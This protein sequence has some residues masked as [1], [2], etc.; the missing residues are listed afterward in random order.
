MGFRAAIA[1]MGHLGVELDP[2]ALAESDRVELAR[3]ISFYKDWR[4]LLHQTH[5]DLGHG[6]DGLLWQS[7]GT[8]TEK[9]LFCVRTSPPQDRRP[10][11][12]RLPFTSLGENWNVRLL[13]VGEQA[14]HGM[15][16]ADLFTRMGKEEIEFSGSWLA[17]NGLPMPVQKAESVAIFHLKA[18]S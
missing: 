9:L 1:C 2:E 3:W 14:G 11:P 6:A 7:Q 5:V 4:H 13:D 10:Q 12:L 16:R 8:S 17:E 15:P 18:K